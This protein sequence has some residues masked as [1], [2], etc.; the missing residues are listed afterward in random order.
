MWVPKLLLSPL[1]IMIFCPRTAKFCPPNCIFGHFGLG[2]A[3]LFGALLVGWSV[4]VARGPYFARHL[5][6]LCILGI[7]QVEDN[8]YHYISGLFSTR[9]TCFQK[10]IVKVARSHADFFIFETFRR[11]CPALDVKHAILRLK[12]NTE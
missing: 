7:H 5:H 4:V 9:T 12:N 3:S 10:K 1:K 2:L 8:R 6:L 11:N